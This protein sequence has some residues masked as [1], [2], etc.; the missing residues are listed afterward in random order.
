MDGQVLPGYGQSSSRQLMSDWLL[1]AVLFSLA[2]SCAFISALGCVEII[3]DCQVDISSVIVNIG[4][5]FDIAAVYVCMI[6]HAIENV[7]CS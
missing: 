4:L 7:V 2:C 6:K 3:A 5:R 1:E